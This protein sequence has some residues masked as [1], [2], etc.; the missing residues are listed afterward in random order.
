MK[1]AVPIEV[2]ALPELFLITLRQGGFP[3]LA[4]AAQEGH[5]VEFFDNF[6]DDGGRGS[7]DHIM[8]LGST[9]KKSRLF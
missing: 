2:Q 8:M 9:L 5:L 6:P 7:F 4:R 1:G 3:H